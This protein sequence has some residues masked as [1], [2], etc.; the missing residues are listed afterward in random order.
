MAE[1]SVD[2]QYFRTIFSKG[3]RSVDS[4]GGLAF[5][6]LR[7]RD[8]KQLAHTFGAVGLQELNIR[9]DTAEFFGDGTVGLA[10]QHRALAFE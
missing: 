7:R 1:I 10:H 9:M 4:H 2:K 5:G 6:R 3:H 8:D